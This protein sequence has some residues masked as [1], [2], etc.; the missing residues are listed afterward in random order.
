VGYSSAYSY[1][2]TLPFLEEACSWAA[3]EATVKLVLMVGH[4]DN[5][6]LGCQ[7]GMDVPSLYE[8]MV[9]I[10]GCDS[11]AGKSRL[12]FVMGH[13]HCNKP[14]PHDHVGAG[15][16]VAGQGM[17][18]CGNYGI[19]IL[20]TTADLVRMFYFPIADVNDKGMDNYDA[21]MACVQQKGWRGCTEQHAV[22]WLNQ[23][24]V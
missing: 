13:T 5:C 21:V 11:F 18:G 19:P 8:E 2:S 24:L 14:H 22:L 9:K 23:S 20:D 1:T 12:K 17:E 16:M 3:G 4:W 6:V 15:F 10:P 7:T